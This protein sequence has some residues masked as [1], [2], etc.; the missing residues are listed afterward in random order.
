[1]LSPTAA[2]I[3]IPRDVIDDLLSR[4]LHAARAIL[5]VVS[6]Y[7]LSARPATVIP[8]RPAVTALRAAAAQ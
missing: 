2:V 7:L 3:A 1:V 5:G 6:S 8:P 4:D